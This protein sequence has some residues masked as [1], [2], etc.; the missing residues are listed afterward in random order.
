METLKKI[1]SRLNEELIIV[2]DLLSIKDNLFD[3]VN[4][5]NFDKDL[6]Q[7]ET[8]TKKFKDKLDAIIEPLRSRE[9]RIHIRNNFGTV[10]V[11]FSYMFKDKEDGNGYSS[12]Y[13]REL[14]WS[15]MYISD[16]KDR[17]KIFSITDDNL[18]KYFIP[19]EEIKKSLLI[20]AKKLSD[21]KKEMENLPYYAKFEIGYINQELLWAKND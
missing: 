11:D 6:K 10:S 4:S 15:L 17:T 1:E 9:K 13:Y 18:K 19:F 2:N 5:F 7:D 21:I 3:A 12:V 8:F 16:T 14:S 20:N